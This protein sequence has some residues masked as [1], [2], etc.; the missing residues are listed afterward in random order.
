MVDFHCTEE[1][2][3][4]FYLKRNISLP[5]LI[6]SVSIEPHLL[7]TDLA[8]IY[9]AADSKPIQISFQLVRALLPLITLKMY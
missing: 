7:R 3:A 5:F 4:F 9:T 2:N 6:Y 8:D 1:L